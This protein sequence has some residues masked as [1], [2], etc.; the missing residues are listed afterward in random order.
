MTYLAPVF[1]GADVSQSYIGLQMSAS[2]VSILSAPVLFGLIAQ[3]WSTDYFA[4]FLAVS[5]AITIVSTMLMK[6]STEK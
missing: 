6:K 2:Y 5:F 4:Y 3:Q 1:F